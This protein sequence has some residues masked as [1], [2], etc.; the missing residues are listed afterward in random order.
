MSGQPGPENAS[1]CANTH[2]HPSRE[3]LPK[4]LPPAGIDWKI[5]SLLPCPR[6]QGDG[7]RGGD[8]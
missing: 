7:D 2:T 3:G 5:L 8:T 4:I 1:V 6:R